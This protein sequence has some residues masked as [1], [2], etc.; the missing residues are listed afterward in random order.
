MAS[1]HHKVPRRQ[2]NLHDKEEMRKF[3]TI[4]VI[5]TLALML[6]MY[7]IFAG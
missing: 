1:K 4:V 5:A 3:L 6:L 2:R 7:F